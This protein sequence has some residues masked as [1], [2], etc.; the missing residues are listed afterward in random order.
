MCIR[1][2]LY[3]EQMPFNAPEEYTLVLNQK[4]PVIRS[5]SEGEKD[6][7]KVLVA[8]ELYDLAELSRQPLS[9]AAMTEF[10]RR[11]MKLLEYVK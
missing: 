1:D 6:E 8:Q 9:P 3:G 2:S 10:L 5:L 4:S 11:S 7:R